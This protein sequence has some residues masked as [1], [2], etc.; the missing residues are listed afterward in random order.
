MEEQGA[1]IHRPFQDIE[2]QMVKTTPDATR[3]HSTCW[4]MKELV[5][6]T[7]SHLE[8]IFETPKVEKGHLTEKQPQSRT[9]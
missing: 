9:M 4:V 7:K 3:T 5:K 8:G 2:N 1:E 6:D